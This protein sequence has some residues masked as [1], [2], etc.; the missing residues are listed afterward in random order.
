MSVTTFLGVENNAETV[1]VGD[2]VQAAVTATVADAS[3]F[4]ATGPFHITI[5]SDGGGAEIIYVESV[6]GNTLQNLVR[7]REGTADADHLDG[8]PVQARVTAQQMSD[9]HDAVNDAEEQL[10]YFNGT[11]LET[12]RVVVSSAAGTI[13]LA[14]DQEGGGDLTLVFSDGFYA[15]DTTPALTIA[16]DV[17]TD[18]V[19]KTN[20]IYIPQAT[21]VLT[22]NNTG[23]P[24]GVEHAHVAKV[25]V[26]SAAT[27]AAKGALL[28]H[29]WT[30][31][32][33]GTDEDGH[34]NDISHWI[35]SQHATWLGG[36][37]PTVAVNATVDLDTTVGLVRQLHEHAIPAFDTSTGTL[38]HFVNDSVTPYDATANIE[39]KLLDA[40][41]VSMSSKYYNLVFWAT[42]SEDTGDCQ[43]FCNL[44]TGSYGKEG[45]AIADI[46][47]YDVFDIPD[48]YRGGAFLILRLTLKHSPAGPTW[49]SIQE[50]DLRGQF[51]SL[52]A[53][54]GTAAIAELFTMHILECPALTEDLAVGVM[55]ARPGTPLGEVGE[56]GE[57]TAIRAK[58]IA[59]TVGAG[60]GA[61]TIL[62]EADDNPAFSSPTVLFT[63]TLTG[64]TEADDT[65]L[66]NAWAAGDIFVRARCTAVEAT[67]PKDVNALF[68]FKER[69][70]S[71]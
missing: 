48:D 32:V 11:V 44:P 14:L 52:V 36:V 8:V 43:L 59:G 69:A 53:G 31:H 10:A 18:T 51:P 54:G 35:R 40:N 61:T 66:D 63:I 62:I 16:L 24:E 65:V 3:V 5:R 64:A 1:L 50:L 60:A 7:A 6:A 39:T 28:V 13:T 57:F 68:Y 42:V 30:D 58:A 26:Q 55:G 2:L 71:F 70:E 45:N 15:L 37:A 38:V 21:K 49:V 29:V 9:I 17:G 67:P 56:H 19:P 41:G 46:S 34:A 20:Y 12:V 22:K 27:V 4:P 33:A 25:I 23:F 47:G